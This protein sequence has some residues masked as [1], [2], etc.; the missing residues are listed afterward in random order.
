MPQQS[1][2]PAEASHR[3]LASIYSDI[4][5]PPE[6]K[7]EELP[8]RAEDPKSGPMSSLS[9]EGKLKLFIGGLYFQSESTVL[10]RNSEIG[11]LYDYFKKYAPILQC[12]LMKDKG[13]TRSR[14]FA[15]VTLQDPGKEWDRPDR[16]EC[17]QEDLLHQAHNQGKVHRRQARRVR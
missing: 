16:R 13:N 4:A 2:T 3:V 10:S 1:A 6:P 12:T 17:A 15:F 11:D 8:H 9:E 7:P 5:P 14:G